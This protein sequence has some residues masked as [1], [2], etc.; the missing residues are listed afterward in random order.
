[1]KNVKKVFLNMKMH[2]LKI[3]NV[4]VFGLI[5]IIHILLLKMNILNLFGGH[6]K[7]A[8]EKKLLYKGHKVVPY[9]PRCGT[10]LIC[11]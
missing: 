2:G 8:W 5:W 11:S 9:C 3:Q 4:L 6:L 7:Q 1:M 10:A